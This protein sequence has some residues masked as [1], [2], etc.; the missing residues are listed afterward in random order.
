[1][2]RG[3]VAASKPTGIWRWLWHV[4][5]NFSVLP[6]YMTSQPRRSQFLHCYKK[7]RIHSD[8]SISVMGV[9]Q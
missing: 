4:L 3:I 5:R 1:M 6:D 2:G 8:L 9:L 7:L